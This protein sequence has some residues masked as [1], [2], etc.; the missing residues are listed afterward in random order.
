[1]TRDQY[2]ELQ[3]AKFDKHFS[4]LTYA[5]AQKIR[6]AEINAVIKST[7]YE[8]YLDIRVPF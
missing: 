8:N 6:P 4:T 5:T 1:M 2:M 7:D 3:D